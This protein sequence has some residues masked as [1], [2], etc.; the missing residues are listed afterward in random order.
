MLGF[1]RLALLLLC[2]LGALICFPNYPLSAWLF[3]GAVFAVGIGVIM[4]LSFI[5]AISGLDRFASFNHVITLIF[6]IAVGYV[7]LWYLP[8]DG[9]VKPIEQL[10]QGKFPT[11]ADLVRGFKQL[12]FNFDFNR[13]GAH[14]EQNF[15]NQQRSNPPA[16]TPQKTES[17]SSDS[18]EKWKSIGIKAN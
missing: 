12:T 14:N 2:L 6:I 9:D 15:S 1:Q 4:V 10:R 7:L 13:R 8:Q 17:N 5:F 11:Q 16:K 18:A 3:I